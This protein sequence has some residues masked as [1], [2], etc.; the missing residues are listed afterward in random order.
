[1]GKNYVNGNIFLAERC[2]KYLEP[3][4]A[5]HTAVLSLKGSSEGQVTDGDLEAGVGGAL[6]LG[7]SLRQ[8]GCWA[9]AAHS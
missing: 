8:T 4:D 9:A 1:M 7:G 6:D 2:K 5:I 3:E